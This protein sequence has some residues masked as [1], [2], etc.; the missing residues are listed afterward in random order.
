[1]WLE[2]VEPLRAEQAR[3]L[4]AGAPG[5]R[6]VDFPSPAQAAGIDDVLVGRIRADRAGEN[7]I[8]LFLAA[9]NLRKGAAL[10][11]IQVAEYLLARQALAV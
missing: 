10:N 6:V 4:L 11:A 8:S 5:V 1:V 7:G 2:T 9:D 3:E